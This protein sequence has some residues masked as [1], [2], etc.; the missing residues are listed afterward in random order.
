[1]ALLPNGGNDFVSTDDNSSIGGATLS[2]SFSYPPHEGDVI[3]LVDVRGTQTIGQFANF[4]EGVIK[5]VGAVPVLPSYHGG[6]GNDFTLTVT[7]LAVGYAGYALAEGNGNQ[8]VEPNECNLLYVSLVNRRSTAV[9]ITKAVLRATNATGAVVT[10]P[11]ATY[12]TIPAGQTMA[13]STPFQFRTD[14]NLPC[15]G[16]VGFELVLDV[17]NEGEFAVNFSPASGSDCSHPTG[18]CGSCAV[19]SGQFTTNTPTTTLP[20][21]FVGAPSICSPPKAYPGTNAATG[22]PPTPYLTHSF[23]NSSTNALCLTAQLDFA[24]PF[25]PTNALGVAAY[26]GNFDPNN[27]SAG[28]LG[29]I[30]QGGPP[31]PAFSFQVPAATNFTLVVMAQTTNL[32]CANYSLEIFGLTCPP[33]ALALEADSVRPKLKVDW[34]TAYPGWT[35]QQKTGITGVFSNAPLTPAIVGGRYTL[36]NITP[37]GQSVLS[38]EEMRRL[39][40][41]G[42]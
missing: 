37:H 14:T 11:A 41:H 39:K 20:I 22:L 34:S 6:D 5:M 19:A 27:P 15:G 31:Y 36:T 42:L 2:T 16:A 30:G 38:P 33:P 13:N 28:Y 3:K 23:T 26:I 32:P 40:T 12:P 24:C 8:T 9:A 29:D 18:P 4:P 7:N 10:I 35:L 21:L 1:M 17:A 25:A